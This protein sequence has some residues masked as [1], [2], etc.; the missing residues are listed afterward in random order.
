M[1]DE[2]DGAIGDAEGSDHVGCVVVGAFCGD[3]DPIFGGAGVV[4]E[5]GGAVGDEIGDEV[6]GGVVVEELGGAAG[7]GDGD[8]VVGGFVVEKLAGADGEGD[9]E[10]VIGCLVGELVSGI[11]V[12][13]AV[14]SN[15][16]VGNEVDGSPLL[17]AP[18]G[19]SVGKGCWRNCGKVPPSSRNF[20]GI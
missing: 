1:I 8:A 16:G 6:V 20:T 12:G 3:G 4:A 14:T 18:S 9:V 11:D 10:V 7:D 13:W 5:L 19:T 15:V 2:F 17:P